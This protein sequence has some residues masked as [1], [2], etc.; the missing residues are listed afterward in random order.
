MTPDWVLD[1]ISDKAK[2]DEASYHPRLIIYEE[3]EEEEEEENEEQY[4]QNEA[5][6]DEKSS[7]ASSREGSP[8]GDQAFSPKSIDADKTKGELMFDDS[9][10]S[11]PEKHERNLNWTTAEVPQTA[12][13][14]SRLPSGK[15]SGLINL[16]ANV[17]PVPGNILSSEIRSNIMASVQNP[18]SSGRPE[19]M[20][21]WS[22]AVRT[23]RNITN[24]AD[25]Q[26]VNRPSNVAHVSILKYKLMNFK[27]KIGNFCEVK[28]M[29]LCHRMY[30]FRS[31]GLQ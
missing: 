4:S 3:E 19:V 20:A 24:N 27:R 12:P 13:T 6:T 22:P 21:A 14:K 30:Y 1:S 31:T 18:Q 28:S 9:S 11:S 7:P 29:V 26:Q 16:C 17:P 15:D 10:D 8:L 25:I 5:S 2:K 23:L